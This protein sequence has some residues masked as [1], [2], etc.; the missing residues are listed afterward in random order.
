[1]NQ[2]TTLRDYTTT[3]MILESI[4]DAIFILNS[5]RG[6]EY[7]NKSALDLINED[8]NTVAGKDFN[9]LLY[10]NI[11]DVPSNSDAGVHEL[12]SAAFIDD[13]QNGLLG[14]IEL[15][16]RSG[17]LL[18]PS[19][20]NFSLISDPDGNPR[21]IIVTAKEISEWKK[22]EKELQ[23]K[24]IIS[25]FQER[26]RVLGELFE[27]L[28][29]S[30][31]QP[32]VTLQLRLELME[33]YIKSEK[34]TKEKL[35]NSRDEMLSLVSTMNSVIENVRTFTR[36][37]NTQHIVP[38]DLN[39]TL[40]NISK[41][42]AY[43]YQKHKIQFEIKSQNNLPDIKSNPMLLQQI[44]LNILK[45]SQDAFEDPI[46]SIDY[47]L[48]Y[49]RKIVVAMEAIEN[50]WIEITFADN[51]GGM[52][53]DV[54][55]KIFDPFFTTRYE[56]NHSGVGLSMAHNIISSLGGDISVEV[57]KGHGSAF[58]VRIPVTQNEEQD[59]LFN[60]IELLNK[61]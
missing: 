54:K 27:G 41:L 43:E 1:M 13:I 38:I 56:E 33:S 5:K 25:I 7:A 48:D 10:Q 55:E 32:L 18:I 39:E 34:D 15:K 21:Y 31:S 40:Q 44:F 22:M 36:Q 12:K 61:K 8:L 29:H 17:D 37:S 28:L 9:T 47:S 45:N 46:E 35:A 58:T 3:I 57:E 19:L 23:H 59:Q 60:L 6:I 26:Q 52:S 49:P 53:D 50:K 14:N 2:E 16:I 4:S 24:Q 20:L 51:A 42:L 30:L 11:T